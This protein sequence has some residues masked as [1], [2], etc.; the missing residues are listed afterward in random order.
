MSL[1]HSCR[2]R[3]N[4]NSNLAMKLFFDATAFVPRGWYESIKTRSH[5]DY[6]Q[7]AFGSCPTLLASTVHEWAVM[8]DISNATGR[9]TLQYSKY[10]CLF[11]TCLSILTHDFILVNIIGFFKIS[12]TDKSY[13]CNKVTLNNFRDKIRIIHNSWQLWET[14]VLHLYCTEQNNARG[15]NIVNKE[16][17]LLFTISQ[18]VICQ[19]A[20]RLLSH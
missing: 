18:D 14:S 15:H 17:T 8:Q 3:I 10:S 4:R 13:G 7:V 16:W 12:V 5:Y 6:P 20:N 2:L 1:A 19:Q 9:K 11:S